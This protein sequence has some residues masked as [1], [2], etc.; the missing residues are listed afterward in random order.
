MSGVNMVDVTDR[1]IFK[2]GFKDDYERVDSELEPLVNNDG[3]VRADFANWDILGNVDPSETRER[4]GAIPEDDLDLG[5]VRAELKEE[6][7]RFG[8][9]DFD[10]YRHNP[11]LQQAQYKKSV[12]GCNKGKDRLIVDT[13]SKSTALFD[14]GAPVSFENFGVYLQ[15][16]NRLIVDDVPSGDNELFMLITPTA[17]AAIL[18]YVEEYKNRDYVEIGA[19]LLYTS[20]SPRDQRGSRMPSSA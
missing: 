7:K 4:D 20:P 1:E 2:D 13:L 5:R 14:G 8:I 18:K 12:I 10:I 17:E 19:C 11:N 15:L 16:V 3:M 9:D 6:Y